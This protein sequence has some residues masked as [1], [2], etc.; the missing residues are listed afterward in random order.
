MAIKKNPFADLSRFEWGLWLFSMAVVGISSAFSA[1][2]SLVSTL[3]SLIGVTALIFVAKGYVLGQVLT[4]VFAI[5]YGVV[6]WQQ[7]YYG[8]MITYLCMTAPMA[9]C[10]VVSW[11]KHP[12]EDSREVQVHKLTKRQFILLWPCAILVT[13]IFYFVLKALGNASLLWS[14]LSITTSFIPSYL[15]YYRS[16]YYAVGYAANDLVLIVLWSISAASDLSYLPMVACF[17]MFLINDLYGFIN[18]KRMQRRQNGKR[19]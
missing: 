13:V 18:W 10:A 1:G 17:V 15:T 11:L 5:F 14:T 12:Y 3:A 9:L 4:I 2:G 19:V 7:K 6:S 8:E 16:P